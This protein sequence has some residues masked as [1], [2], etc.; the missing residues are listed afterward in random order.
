MRRVQNNRVLLVLLTI[1]LVSFPLSIVFSGNIGDLS[2]DPFLILKIVNPISWFSIVVSVAAI[3]FLLRLNGFSTKIDPYLLFCALFPL[4]VDLTYRYVVA[5]PLSRELYHAAGIFYVLKHGN[6]YFPGFLQPETVAPRILGATFAMITSTNPLTIISYMPSFFYPFLFSLCTYTVA[7]KLQISKP[8]TMLATVYATSASFYLMGMDRATYCMPLYVLTAVPVLRIIGHNRSSS[9]AIVFLLLCLSLALSDMEFLMLAPTLAL[10]PL[11]CY[12]VRITKIGKGGGLE[13]SN[14]FVNSAILTFTVF[15]GWNLFTN[16]ITGVAFT[17]YPY[18]M[19]ERFV[20]SLS[21]ELS[22]SSFVAGYNPDLALF[23][24]TRGYLIAIGLSLSLILLLYFF[25]GRLLHKNHQANTLNTGHLSVVL[26]YYIPATLL[27]IYSYRR[28][29]TAWIPIL[30][31]YILMCL[32]RHG[33]RRN[34]PSKALRICTTSFIILIVLLSPAI[35]WV[36]SSTYVSVREA[37]EL[38]YLGQA[39]PIRTGAY[40]FNFGHMDCGLK[41]IFSDCEESYVVDS[42]HQPYEIL[43]E[44]K[45]ENVVRYHVIVIG[46]I[47]HLEAVYNINA[48]RHIDAIIE[49]ANNESLNIIYDSGYPYYIF[50]NAEER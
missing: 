13:M 11:I 23:F 26:A 33:C 16:P 7:R 10:I 6:V 28:T 21:G 49:T 8:M 40:M 20:Q 46:S 19:F 12:I 18:I 32:T 14:L 34:M 43:N 42:F 31:V 17:H 2:S 47:K 41:Y 38:A 48:T 4:Y 9:D 37:K 1:T 44:W 39:L 5:L 45:I 15:V 22:Q 35:T 24:R 25:I 36:T 29:A 27:A 50:Y 3:I 30:T